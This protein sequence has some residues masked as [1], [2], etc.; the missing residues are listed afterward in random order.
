[1]LSGCG[2]RDGPI[3][4][5]ENPTE[6]GVSDCNLETKTMRMPRPTIAVEP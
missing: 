6:C 3:N 5:P 4:R 2:L 1:M